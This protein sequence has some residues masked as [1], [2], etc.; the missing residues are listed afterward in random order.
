[1]ADLELERRTLVLLVR[2]DDAPHFSDEAAE[3][4]Q[5]EHIAFLQRMRDEGHMLI[6]GPIRN[7][8]DERLRG[9]CLYRSGIEEAIRLASEDPAVERRRLAIEAMDWF[10]RAGEFPP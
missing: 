10:A 2:P 1:M 6:A 7:Q 4:L 8:P 5:A 9:A 3:A